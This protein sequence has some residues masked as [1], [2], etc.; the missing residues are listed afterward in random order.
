MANAQPSTDY[1]PEIYPQ[2]LKKLTDIMVNDVTSPVAA[3]RYYAYI[4]LAGYEIVAAL[5]PQYHSFHGILNEFPHITATSDTKSASM[6]LA[7]LYATLRMGEELLPSG[8]LL[9]ED[10]KGLLRESAAMGLSAETIQS[11]QAFSENI[12]A[13]VISYSKSDHFASLSTYARYTP[14]KG[15]AYWQPTPPAYMAP[16]EPNWDMLR[17]FLLDSADQFKPALPV[18]YSEKKGSDFFRLM[19]EVYSTTI[20][21]SR[22]Q[23]EIAS[24]WDCNP[25]VLH[26]YGHLDFGMKKISPGAHWIGITGIACRQAGLNFEETVRSHALTA[27][28]LADAFISCWDE[29]FRSNRVRPETAINRLADRSWRPLLQT[30]PFPEYT[31]GHSVVSTT[32]AYV[33]TNLFGDNFSFTDTIEAEFGLPPR[34]F[35]SFIQASE[36]AAISRLYGGIHYT[37]AIEAGITQGK[38]IAGLVNRKAK[39]LLSSGPGRL[40][41]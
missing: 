29:K 38:Q 13:Q 9:E 6:Q 26:T 20:N 8:F 3:S 40:S 41:E 31:S 34:D 11:S 7:I 32:A 19:Y 14:R 28:A 25:F 39:R 27:V 1:R 17:P 12:I 5:N 2:T 24:F 16:V 4:A 36:E 35:I 23:R 22:E 30:P 15:A 21:M 18:A 33:L 10:R 37:D